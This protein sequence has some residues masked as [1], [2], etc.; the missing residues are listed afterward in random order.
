MKEVEIYT[1]KI[2]MII[3]NKQINFYSFFDCLRNLSVNE[4]AVSRQV[5][6]QWRDLLYKMKLSV[7]LSVCMY[8]N[9]SR[10]TARTSLKQTPTIKNI[11]RLRPSVFLI[12]DIRFINKLKLIIIFFIKN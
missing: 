12:Y 8:S 9:I 3:F 5:K 6:V 2:K 1:N 7:F 10:N 11:P 4:I